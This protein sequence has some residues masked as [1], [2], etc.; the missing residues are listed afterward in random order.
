MSNGVWPTLSARI[1]DVWAGAIRPFYPAY[2][3]PAVRTSPREVQAVIAHMRANPKPLSRPVLIL[4]GYHGYAGL[5]YSHRDALR[6]HTSKRNADFL[7]V[8][9]VS[10]TSIVDAATRVLIAV[11]EKWGDA[12]GKL[13]QLDVLGISMG[14]LVARWCAMSP[15]ARAKLPHSARQHGSRNGSTPPISLNIARLFTFASPHRGA[16]LADRIAPDDAGRAMKTNSQ[17]VA[18]LNAPEVMSGTNI[19]TLV[20]YTQLRD[21]LVGAKNTSPPGMHPCWV[22]GPPLFSHFTA[23]RNPIVFADV[24]RQLRGEERILGGAHSEPP[25]M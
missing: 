3:N 14:G 4:N 7:P 22:D 16:I 6:E 15:E 18:A 25:R 24:A 17:F 8:S 21:A 23:A 9:Y 19:E 13:P 20:C 2:Q 1:T 5:A 12:Q 10:A 11:Q